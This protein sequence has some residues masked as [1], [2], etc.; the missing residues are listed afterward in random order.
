MSKDKSPSDAKIH[1]SE[2]QCCRCDN[3]AVA[4]WP[5]FDPDIKKHPF[6][7]DCLDDVERELLIAL[8]DEGLI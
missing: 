8:S 7:R 6:C 4:F 5:A 1:A 2:Y 3:Q